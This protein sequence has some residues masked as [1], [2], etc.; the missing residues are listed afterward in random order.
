MR[1]CEENRVPFL[2]HVK[3]CFVY[4]TNNNNN[5][6]NGLDVVLGK[7]VLVTLKINEQRSSRLASTQLRTARVVANW[8]HIARDASNEGY[9]GT[10]APIWIF[11]FNFFAS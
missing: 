5:T 7:C 8:Q 3:F 1:V 4:V 6:K 10:N 11:L 2:W 9:F